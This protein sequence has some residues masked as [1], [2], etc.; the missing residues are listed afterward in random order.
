M[1][2]RLIG[3]SPIYHKSADKESIMSALKNYAGC[4]YCIEEEVLRK[5][6]KIGESRRLYL[7]IFTAMY[8]CVFALFS[9]IGK[10]NANIY[11]THNIPLT[12]AFGL[13]GMI[14]V[15]IYKLRSDKHSLYLYYD[16][17]GK[18]HAHQSNPISARTTRS[19]W[20]NHGQ[21]WAPNPQMSSDV[22][23]IS[24]VVIR[25]RWRG[26]LFRTSGYNKIFEN[27]TGGSINWRIDNHEMTYGGPAYTIGNHIADQQKIIITLSQLLEIANG[28][29]S[30]DQWKDFHQRAAQDRHLLGETVLT[31]INYI[32]GTKRQG[33]SKVGTKA[34]QLLST[35]LSR[36]AIGTDLAIN[37]WNAQSDET[38]LQLEQ[39]I[40]EQ[41]QKEQPEVV[42]A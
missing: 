19:A 27:R 13:V 17:D 10:P 20:I 3:S 18:M 31:V 7:C 41:D 39:I 9:S 15:W 36:L 2:K 11:L 22:E 33:T 35:G 37:D 25:L 23:H 24:G 38:L 32:Q 5:K 1:Q 4:K 8:L 34:R 14:A 28:F 26:W 29:G 30:L 16:Q 12:I 6:D 40:T 21:K 42:S